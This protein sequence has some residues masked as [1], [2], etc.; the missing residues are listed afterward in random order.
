MRGDAIYVCLMFFLVGAI[1]ARR[2][3]VAPPVA[4]CFLSGGPRPSL[5][6]PPDADVDV[7]DVR[8]RAVTWLFGRIFGLQR[9]L[10]PSHP[11]VYSTAPAATVGSSTALAT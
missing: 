8:Q 5:S 1:T 2:V 6:V 10:L 11:C 7:V 4:F 3:A 9:L